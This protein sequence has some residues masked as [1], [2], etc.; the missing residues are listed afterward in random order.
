M[1]P[2]DDWKCPLPIPPSYHINDDPPFCPIIRCILMHFTVP[3]HT[4]EVVGA[5]RGAVIKQILF[6]FVTSWKR[7]GT[8]WW[9]KHGNTRFNHI[10]VVVRL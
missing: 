5:D 9:I 3:L 2:P 4:E 6:P 1:T 8:L 10:F 7:G